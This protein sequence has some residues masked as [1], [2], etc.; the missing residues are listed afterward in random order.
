MPLGGS[1][2]VDGDCRLTGNFDVAIESAPVR[3]SGELTT[4]IPSRLY[5]ETWRQQSDIALESHRL[6]LSGIVKLKIEEDPLIQLPLPPLYVPVTVSL[7]AD[8]D[9]PLPV[10]QFPMDVGQIWGINDTVLTLD[11][12][13]ESIWLKAANVINAILLRLGMELIPAELAELLPVLGHDN[14]FNLPAFE[15]AFVCLAREEVT[16]P[17]GTYD[18]FKVVVLGGV[19]TFYYAPDAERII[20]T[21]VDGEKVSTLTGDMIQLSDIQIELAATG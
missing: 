20:K 1:Y 3:V 15:Y 16:V 17:A 5:G 8:L 6:D 4:L 12:L 11:G 13:V 21:T 2:R 10:L 18:T 7:D 19:A 14:V 9:T